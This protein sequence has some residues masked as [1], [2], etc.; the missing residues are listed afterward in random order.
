MKTGVPSAVAGSA[1]FDMGPY[2]K[3]FGSI[4]LTLDTTYTRA[5]NKAD[6]RVA[7][8]AAVIISDLIK[9]RYTQ[10]NLNTFFAQ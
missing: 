4:A 3:T 5:A 10:V 8:T 1:N 9:Q 7:P 2:R 6:K